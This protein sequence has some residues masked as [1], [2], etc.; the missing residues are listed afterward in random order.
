MGEAH[1]ALSSNAVIVIVL[2]SRIFADAVSSKDNKDQGNR[3]DTET[4]KASHGLIQHENA[5]EGCSDRWGRH[6]GFVREITIADH[7]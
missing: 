1:F 7:T 4:A 2:E 5:F 3:S 6:G